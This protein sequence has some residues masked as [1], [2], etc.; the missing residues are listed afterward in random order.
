M[1]SRVKQW[2]VDRAGLDPELLQRDW[3]DRNIQRRV[4]QLALPGEDSYCELLE[5]DPA[6]RER[7]IREVSVGETSFFR[8]PASYDLLV[9]HVRRLRETAGR[10]TLRMLSVACATGEEPYSMALSAIQAGWPL[11]AVTVEAVDRNAG[12]LAVARA[13][14]Y[15]LHRTR[16]PLPAW[17]SPWLRVDDQHWCITPALQAAVNFVCADAVAAPDSVPA[18]PYAVV[19]CRNLLIYLHDEARDRLVQN[20]ARWLAA[21]GLLFVGHAEQVEALRSRFRSVPCPGAFALQAAATVPRVAAEP[22]APR[23]SPAPARVGRDRVPTRTIEASSTRNRGLPPTGA[24]RAPLGTPRTA[25]DVG[26]GSGPNP[27]GS[28]PSLVEQALA[29]AGQGDLDT[30]LTRLQAALRTNPPAAELYQLLGSIQLAQGSLLEARDALRRAVYLDPTHE[31]SLLQLALVYQQLGDESHA[32]RYRQR[33]AR[34][35]Q[36]NAGGTER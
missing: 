15:S 14:R 10:S 28:G 21:D 27:A 26:T 29:A 16:Q 11:E 1:L 6:E 12:N 34:A 2:L 36:K 30:A 22:S 19:F 3:L 35:H 33:A 4:Q 17:T 20:L 32:A 24:D 25:E 5:R 9:Q 8:Y 18:G 13:G 7:L 31:E 23:D